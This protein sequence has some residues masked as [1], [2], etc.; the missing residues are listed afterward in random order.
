MS[1][2]L[3]ARRPEVRRLRALLRDRRARAA[4]HAFVVEGPRAVAAALDRDGALEAV[5]LGYRAEPAFGTLVARL[6]ERGVPV[7]ELKEGVLEKVGITRTPQPVLAVAPVRRHSLDDLDDRG[8]V[9]VAV[10]VSDPGNLGTVVRGAEAADAAGIVTCA[11]SVDVYNPKAVRSSAG[12]VFAVTVVEA[13][14]PVDVLEELARRGPRLGA[15]PHGGRPYECVDLTQPS[16]FVLGNEAHGL[17]P[18]VAAHLDGE[19]TVPMLGAA[20][21]LNVGMAA[22]VLLFEAARQ[23]RLAEAPS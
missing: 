20:E 18:D 21:S 16:C 6:R 17:A 4:E 5:Y 13:G 1:E 9:V 12:A 14:E 10:G 15:T 7:L 2:Q 23:R 11:N 19:V 8:P 3:G 22:T